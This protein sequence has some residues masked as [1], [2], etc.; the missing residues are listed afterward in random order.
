MKSVVLLGAPGAGKGTIA[1]IL[2]ADA[3]FIH[4]STG[5][6]LR[7]AVKKGTPVGKKAGECM[8]RGDLVPDD[9]IIDIVME[10][11][12]SGDPDGKYLFDGFPRTMD[13]ALLLDENLEQRGSSVDKV[14]LLYVPVDVTVDRLTGRRICRNCG[15]N[16]HIRNIPPKVDGVCDKCGGELYQ[17]PDDNEATIRNRLD[18]FEKQTSSLVGYYEKK[19]ILIKIDSSGDKNETAAAIAGQL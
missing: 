10:R 12:E 6:M 18:V 7:D 16:Y 9:V 4:I 2:K 8:K 1:E 17:R 5:D 3:G 19:K 13:Q 14:F 15:A 11:L